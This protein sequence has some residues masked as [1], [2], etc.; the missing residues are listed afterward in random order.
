MKS[1]ITFLA[2][3]ALSSVAFANPAGS[4]HSAPTAKAAP[5]APAAETTA[6]DA[7]SAHPEKMHG[8][9]KADKKQK[10]EGTTTH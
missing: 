3:A 6:T 9:K 4:T 2:A 10:G 8:K 1:I 7:A 5:T